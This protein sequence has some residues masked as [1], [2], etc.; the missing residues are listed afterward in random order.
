MPDFSQQQVEQTI[1]EL[2]EELNK[3]TADLYEAAQRAANARHAYRVAHARAYLNAEG[4]IQQREARATLVAEGYLQ[5]RETANAAEDSLKEAGRNLRAQLEGQRTIAAN[6]RQA[7][8]HTG[9][10]S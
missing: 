8:E 3:I 4:P 1:H 10:G 9:V 6:M 5:E 2:G 7:I